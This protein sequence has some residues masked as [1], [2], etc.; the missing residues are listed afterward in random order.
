M[1]KMTYMLDI[2]KNL[3][4]IGYDPLIDEIVGGGDVMEKLGEIM[5]R[6]LKKTNRR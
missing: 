1:V 5:N 2:V 4:L 6:N 3:K